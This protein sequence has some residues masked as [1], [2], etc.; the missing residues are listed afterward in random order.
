MQSICS[1]G[2]GDDDLL[3]VKPK[4]AC[5][6][7]NCG[8]THLYELLAAREIQSFKDGKSR[9]IVVQSMRDYIARQLAKVDAP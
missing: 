2:L 9:K 4:R 7:L 6:M 5:Q 8:I 1:T 3:L